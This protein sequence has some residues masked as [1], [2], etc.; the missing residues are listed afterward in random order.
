ME[1]QKHVP[2]WHVGANVWVLWAI[3]ALV[4]IPA[5]AGAVYLAAEKAASGGRELAILLG[6]I[7]AIPLIIATWRH[8]TELDRLDKENED[9]PSYMKHI[10]HT[11][12]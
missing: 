12:G 4:G 8:E 10:R 6:V 7:A 1:S 11:R 9:E 5:I 3:A 2:W